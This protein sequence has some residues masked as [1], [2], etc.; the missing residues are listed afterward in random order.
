MLI[1]F[2]KLSVNVI[3]GERKIET[4]KT[5]DQKTTNKQ[6]KILP[7]PPTKGASAARV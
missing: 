3:R 6:S 5:N 1:L 2:I 4:R 7:Q